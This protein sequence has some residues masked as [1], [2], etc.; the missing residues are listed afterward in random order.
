MSDRPKPRMKPADLEYVDFEAMLPRQKRLAMEHTL[1][2][3]VLLQRA[4]N[5]QRAVY[6]PS[7]PC[8]RLAWMGEVVKP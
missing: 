1:G 2:E 5:G 7:A 3:P 6:I 4:N 8:R